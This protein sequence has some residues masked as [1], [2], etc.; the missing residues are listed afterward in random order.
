M[1]KISLKVNRKLAKHSLPRSR[2][3]IAPSLLALLF[4]FAIFFRPRG[5]DI[6]PYSHDLLSSIAKTGSGRALLAL[7]AGLVL[8]SGG[9][10]LSVVGILAISGIFFA[11]AANLAF[12]NASST[13]N[14]LFAA[15]I[16][17]LLLGG[18]LGA[19]NGYA[20][21]RWKAPPLILTWAVGAILMIFSSIAALGL[22][23]LAPIQNYQPVVSGIRLPSK[24]ALP[25]IQTQFLYGLIFFLLVTLP[26]VFRAFNLGRYSS[27]IGANRISAK[28]AG[29]RI[30]RTIILTY[31]I[32][33]V[34]AS[35][36]GI[37]FAIIERKALITDHVGLELSAIA[38]AVLG[39]TAMS[40]GYFSIYPIVSA[41]FLWSLLYTFL[42]NP[43]I[44]P[45]GILPALLRNRF[46]EASFALILIFVVIWAGRRLSGDTI[47]INVNSRI[48]D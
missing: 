14:I 43:Q 9:V 36:A 3:L 34:F 6:V 39:G 38:I 29:I 10:D 22:P 42:Q 13:G 5:V 18:S 48:Q 35:A 31:A 37:W 25:F 1:A 19:L 17:C 4:L 45:E 8:A 11:W 27:A 26:I 46:T 33:G 47:P 23:R 24:I 28:Y 16:F 32:S 20:I 15:L 30:R 40:G 44:F 7:G 12:A 2:E 41:A 21:S